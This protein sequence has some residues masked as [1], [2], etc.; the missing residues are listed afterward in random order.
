MIRVAICQFGEEANTFSSGCLE[1]DDLCPNGWVPGDRV[2]QQFAGTRTYICGA[3]DAIRDAGATAVPMAI[4]AA[5]GANFVAGP[6]LSRACLEEATERICRELSRRREEYDCIFFAM[7]GAACADGTEDVEGHVLSAVRK[8]VGQVKIMSSL[9]L[10]GNITPQMVSLSD[11]FI[12]LKTVPHMDCYDAGYQAARML[13]RTM[14]GQIRPV[15]ALRRLPLLVS[16]P[17]GSTLQGTARE[18]KEHFAQYAQ[19]H[20]LLDACFFHGFSSTDRACSSASVLVVADGY[21]PD[22]EADELADFV[23]QRRDG[24]VCSSLSARE[25]VDQALTQIK[26]GYVVINESSDNPGSGCPGDATHLLRELIYRDLPRSIMGPVYDPAAAKVCHSHKVGDRFALEVGGHKE[27]ISGAPLQLEQV[28]LLALC[29]GNFVS[30]SPV[31]KGVRMCFGPSARLKAGNV[32]F[33]VVSERFQ[34]FDDRPFLM[35][36]CNM[37]NYSI[38]GLKSMNH[39]R[40]YFAPVADA[41]VSADTPGLRPANLKN[42]DYQQVLRPIYPLDED[43]QYRGK[44]PQ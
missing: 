9:D 8:A 29:D 25:A 20:G 16:A 43:T 28:E 40:G 4:P 34:T 39:F 17:M 27:P 37:R 7:H 3:L 32:E 15:M 41:I 31:N 1:M 24:F 21:V 18:V 6:I 19:T 11:G 38:V 26:D 23:W 2:Q 33:I 44:W 5:N 42:L 14:D 10:H 13:C 12:G 30:A 35:T 22:R 36:G